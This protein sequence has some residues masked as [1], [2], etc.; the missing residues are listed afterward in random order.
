MSPTS[1]SRPPKP[2]LKWM[3][4][5]FAFA[6]NLLLTTAA[7]LLVSGPSFGFDAEILAT[8]IAPVIAGILTAL[9]VKQRGGMHAF[10]GGMLSVPVLALFTFGQNWQFALL[11]GAF[12]ALGGALTELTLRWRS[13]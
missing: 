5:V 8:A 13:A 10:L 11:S 9:Y 1:S 4:I 3:G 12:C 6:T 7:E 2:P